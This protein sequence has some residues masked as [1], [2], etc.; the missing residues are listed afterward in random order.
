M[1]VTKFHLIVICKFFDML[2]WVERSILVSDWVNE[3]YDR[4]LQY[5]FGIGSCVEV[6]CLLFVGGRHA[7]R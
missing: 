4:L 2:S 1:A 5:T 6:Y 3:Y 7:N